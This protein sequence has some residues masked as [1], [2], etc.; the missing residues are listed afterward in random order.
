MLSPGWIS[1]ESVLYYF[2]FHAISLVLASRSPTI[3]EAGTLLCTTNAWPAVTH[4]CPLSA[5]H[6][7]PIKDNVDRGIKFIN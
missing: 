6:A 1:V 4:N 7:C 5:P 2:W 3:A